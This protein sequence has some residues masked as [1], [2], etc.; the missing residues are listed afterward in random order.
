[1]STPRRFVATAGLLLVLALAL[2]ACIHE[3]RSVSLQ[4]DGS[5]TY[6]L[7]IGLNS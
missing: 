7:T 4:G 1:M 5:G 2:T 6:T 3:D